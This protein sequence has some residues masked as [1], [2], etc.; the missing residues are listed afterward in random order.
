MTVHKPMIY[1]PCRFTPFT[2]RTVAE[3]KG[4]I[5]EQSGKN[6]VSRTFKAK[7]D[8]EKIAAWNSKL[9]RILDIFI[10]CFVGPYKEVLMMSHSGRAGNQY[11]HVGCRHTSQRGDKS[12]I[13]QLSRY[14]FYP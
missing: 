11:Q 2:R 3:I 9:N 6:E 8:K 10:V 4:K 13:Q 14:D 7:G 5:M 12:G 1:N